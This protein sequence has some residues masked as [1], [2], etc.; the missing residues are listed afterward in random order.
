MYP[1]ATVFSSKCHGSSYQFTPDATAFVIRIH[2]RIKQKR[3]NAS[4]A[5]QFD[6]PNKF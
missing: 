1:F 4:I 3:V 2:G 6:K 5:D